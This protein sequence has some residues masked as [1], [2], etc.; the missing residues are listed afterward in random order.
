MPEFNAGAMEN[1]GCVTH[2]E[3]MVFRDPPT[4]NQRLGRAETI[5]HEMAHMWFGDLV[6]MRW[7]NDLW[8]NESFATYMATCAS[9]RRRASQRLAGLQRGHQELGLPPGPARHH[10]PDRGQVA[11]TDETFLNFDGITYGK[12]ASVLKQLVPAIGRGRLPRRHALLL[13]APRLRQCDARAVPGALEEG[14]GD[15]P[16]GV[17]ASCGSKQRRSTPSRARWE[18]DGDR[19]TH[20]TLTQTAPPE[21]PDAAPAPPRS[22]PRSRR[23]GALRRR[24]LS[25]STFDGAEAEVPAAVGLPHSHRSSSRTTTTTATPRSHSIRRSLAFVREQHGAIEDTLL[26]QLLW[27]SLWNMVR[28]QQ[29]SSV[30]FLSFVRE[31][32]PLE[33]ANEL[34]DAVLGQANAALGRYVPEDRREA[35]F[36]LTFLTNWS[37]DA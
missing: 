31:K 30:D 24:R 7:W 12:G 11:D 6:T 15:G 3:Y 33:P 1:V 13:P 17:G 2:N 28:D 27:S 26:R 23:F 19:I 25:Q 4:D 10:A 35:E 36:H 21:L 29:L 22:R 18:A 32:L 34:V 16:A 8:L 9:T 37:R 14:S 5:L 20:L